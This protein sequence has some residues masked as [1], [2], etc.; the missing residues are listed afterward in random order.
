M[1]ITMLNV[2]FTGKGMSGGVLVTRDQ[3]E[4]QAQAAGHYPQ[5]KVDFS[6][7]YLVASRHDTSKAMAA[8]R[9]GVRVITYDQWQEILATGVLNHGT[10]NPFAKPATPPKPVDLEGMDELAE[11]GMF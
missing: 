9:N 5:K 7:S 2:C 3:W 8:A 1:G 11:W 6:T 4:A 10:P